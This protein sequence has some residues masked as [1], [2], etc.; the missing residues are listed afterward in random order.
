MLTR[1]WRCVPIEPPV[2]NSPTNQGSTA[3]TLEVVVS[4]LNPSSGARRQ[5]RS[6]SACVSM[7][8]I[9]QKTQPKRH[10]FWAG[11]IKPVDARTAVVPI[12]VEYDRAAADQAQAGQWLGT[13]LLPAR[14]LQAESTAN[15]TLRCS[16]ATSDAMFGASA[17]RRLRSSHQQGRATLTTAS[18]NRFQWWARS[19]STHRGG[20]FFG[21]N[22]LGRCTPTASHGCTETRAVHRC[23]RC[24][25]R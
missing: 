17:S 15:S 18:S 12:M 21:A 13:A 7:L 9:M 6:N 3:V 8:W 24:L 14:V 5:E 1:Q 22:L 19:C 23:Q 2:K 16:I 10:R 4:S 11:F 20:G 25:P